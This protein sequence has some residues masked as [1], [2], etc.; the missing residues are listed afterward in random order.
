MDVV[1]LI[2]MVYVLAAMAY[3]VL[4]SRRNR[5]E[6]AEAL[7]VSMDR[8]VGIISLVAYN[9]ILALA[10]VYHLNLHPNVL[11]QYITPT[12]STNTCRSRGKWLRVLRAKAG[13]V[14]TLPRASATQLMA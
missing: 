1:H 2:S 8:R 14:R 5:A 6:M 3:A 4:A 12:F 9:A 7:T 13:R 11:N 10:L